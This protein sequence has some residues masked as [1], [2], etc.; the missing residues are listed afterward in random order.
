M[1]ISAM[2][3]IVG[4]DEAVERAAKPHTKTQ[5]RYLFRGFIYPFLLRG[6]AEAN[7]ED[8]GGRGI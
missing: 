7:E 3:R 6:E 8:I 4:K 2:D 1:S 5:R